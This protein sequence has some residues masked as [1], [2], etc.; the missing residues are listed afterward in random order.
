MAKPTKEDKIRRKAKKTQRKSDKNEPEAYGETTMGLGNG[1]TAR[2][3]EI[4]KRLPPIG[5]P[6]RKR[7]YRGLEAA[8]AVD[9]VHYKAKQRGSVSNVFMFKPSES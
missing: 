7:G 1:S 3:S 8:N 4:Q 9:P 2:K 6:N 5:C